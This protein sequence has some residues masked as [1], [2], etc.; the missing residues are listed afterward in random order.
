MY[1]LSH[2]IGNI[3][4]GPHGFFAPWQIT[5]ATPIQ[6]YHFPMSYNKLKPLIE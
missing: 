6:T 4:I 2:P 5:A 3:G 1:H